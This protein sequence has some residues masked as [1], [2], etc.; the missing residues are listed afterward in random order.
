MVAK[1]GQTTMKFRF[2]RIS[3]NNWKYFNFML[4]WNL[5]DVAFLKK[6]HTIYKIK[7]TEKRADGKMFA[8][9]EI[10]E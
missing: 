6:V 5:T 1:N 7:W 2:E 10:I 8:M 3:K 4:D 9:L